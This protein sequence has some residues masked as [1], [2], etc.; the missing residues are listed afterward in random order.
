MFRR[1]FLVLFITFFCGF[2][3]CAQKGGAG[4][5]IVIM[6]S[7]KAGLTNAKTPADKIQFLLSLSMSCLDTSQAESYNTQ[8][9]EIA[10][11]SRDRRL[12]A[13]TYLMKGR[14]YLNNTAL[15]ENLDKALADLRRA[16]EIA[17]VNNLE[18]LLEESYRG[19]SVAWHGKGD[20][21]RAIA[22]A[23]Q[24]LSMAGNTE[25]DTLKV[26][27]Y[28]G[29]GEQYLNM[30]EK[31][32]SFRNFLEALSIAESSGNESLARD[33]YGYLRRFYASIHD[34]G[35]AIDYGMKEY[36]FDRKAWDVFRMI[37]DEYELGDLFAKKQQRDLALRMYESAIA[38]AD[39]IHYDLL[40]IDP[41]FRIFNMYFQNK[42]YVKGLNY[43][44]ERQEVIGTLQVMGYSSYIDQVYAMSFSQQG[45]FDSA[46]YYFRRAEPDME[47][48]GSPAA[49]Y[50]FYSAEGD[51]YVRR[52]N[53]ARAVDYYKKAFDIGESVKDM[54]AQ[55][56]SAGLLDS[57]YGLIGDYRSA[58]YYNIRYHGLKDSLREMSRDADLLKLEVES[59]NQRRERLAKEEEARVE[60]RHN[61]Q[62]L[63]FTI[64]LVV[65]FI[66]LVMLGWFA[67]PAGFIRA[68]GFVSFIFLFEFI[69]LLADKTIA[70]WT[71]EEPWKVLV[72]KI[73]LAAILV[74]MHHWLEHKVIHY[75][76]HR[77]KRVGTKDVQASV[78]NKMQELGS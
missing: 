69:I 21:Q 46:G 34:Y 52:K 31:L 43:L 29:M 67:V 49:R 78:E 15:T 58:R 20:D 41:Y 45:N 1:Y 77:R 6:D 4:A 53:Y 56:T 40:K 71:H 64:G 26:Y 23:N 74:P 76:S 14:R 3:V 2:F 16:E 33:V 48:N 57:V 73:G 8:A 5:G 36:A 38:L 70:H 61:V 39:T 25:N 63:G 28:L 37:P 47:R 32:L 55:Q 65:L 30:D 9:V 24:A 72:I 50:E 68:L 27:A 12:M 54:N 7:L 22:F 35:K 42:E 19:Q 44:K 10:E 59:D 66:L 18:F 51:D 60:R 13:R 75:L 11:M 17:R 62:Y